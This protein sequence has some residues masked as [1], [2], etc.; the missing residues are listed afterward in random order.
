MNSPKDYWVGDA[1][2]GGLHPAGN[3]TPS[4]GPSVDERQKTLEINPIRRDG[5]VS[6]PFQPTLH[7]V[8]G[9]PVTYKVSFDWG[10]VVERV[11]GSGNAVNLLEPI[12][13]L[14]EGDPTRFDIV[15]GQA[16]YLA[17]EVDKAGGISSPI[18]EEGAEPTPAV[19]I[20]VGEDNRQSTH[21]VPVVDN[22]TPGAAG[23]MYYKLMVLKTPVAPS[24]SPTVEKWLAGS[25]VSHYQELPSIRSTFGAGDG[26]GVITKEWNNSGKYYEMRVVSKGTGRNNVSTSGDEVIVR[27][28]KRNADVFVWE[29]DGPRPSARQFGWEDGYLMTGNVVEV[30]DDEAPPEPQPIDI[31]IPDVRVIRGLTIESVGVDGGKVFEIGMPLGASLGD[32]LYWDGTNWILLP[33]PAAPT[34]GNRWVLHHTGVAP[35]Y[36]SYEELEV[37]ICISGVPTP[38]KILGVPNPP[39]L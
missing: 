24:T 21:Y 35:H 5:V 8:P 2:D 30:N 3:I 36:V 17:V 9:T 15:V 31:K 11:P 27:G 39:P 20:E 1:V 4:F 13:R 7:R 38:Y 19:R 29:G 16:V 23:T 22:L 34:A 28:T 26:V 25:H 37:D 18:P 10:V 12:N 33:A 14:T 6:I 32:M